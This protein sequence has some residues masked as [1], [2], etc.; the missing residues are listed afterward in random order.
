[1]RDRLCHGRRSLS[2]DFGFL[3]GRYERV[4]PLEG[5]RVSAG[6][7]ERRLPGGMRVSAG[8]VTVLSGVTAV[9][10]GESV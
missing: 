10:V 4:S 9:T 3:R 7:A 5:M 8:P 6:A 2:Q 1:M